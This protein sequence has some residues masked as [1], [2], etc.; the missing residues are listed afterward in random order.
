[1]I[2]NAGSTDG[3]SNGRVTTLPTDLHENQYV[4]RYNSQPCGAMNYT[5]SPVICGNSGW[6][7]EEAT[8][9]CRSEKSSGYGLGG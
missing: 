3:C 2:T 9:V 1:M 7:D 4:V 5:Q 8:V 6:G